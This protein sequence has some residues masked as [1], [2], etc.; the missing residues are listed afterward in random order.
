[1][2]T[3][4]GTL[5]QSGVVSISE[6]PQLKIWVE[7]IQE[8]DNG[9]TPDLKIEE[10]F[11]PAETVLPPSGAQISLVVRPW[12]SGKIVRYSGVKLLPAQPPE[13]PVVSGR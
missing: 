4:T 1:M 10:F 13:R 6:K 7:H 11:L 8:R 3:L 12:A 5:R 2:I 9:G